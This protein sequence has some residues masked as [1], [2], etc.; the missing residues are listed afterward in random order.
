NAPPDMQSSF[1]QLERALASRPTVPLENYFEA[2]TNNPSLIENI[3]QLNAE[4]VVLSSR[5]SSLASR[6]WA[7]V[8]EPMIPHYLRA[9]T[10]PRGDEGAVT[11]AEAEA[12]RMLRL[13]QGT[14]GTGPVDRDVVQSIAAELLALLGRAERALAIVVACDDPMNRL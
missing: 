1:A 11:P 9:A 2:Y 12:L 5:D 13:L 6:E 14:V 3:K 8:L 4:V 10:F 7:R